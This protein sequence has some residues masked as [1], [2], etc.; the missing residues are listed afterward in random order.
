MSIVRVQRKVRDFFVA[1]NEIMN[2]PELSF[3]AKGLWAYAMSRP[4]DWQFSIEHLVT[5]SKE[6]RTAIYSAIKELIESGYCIKDQKKT[7]E[8]KW[9]SMDYVIFETLK[10]SE[11]FKKS[12]PHSGFPQ[13]DFPL[14]ENQPLLSTED[15]SPIS[16]NEQ[17]NEKYK[18]GRD[19]PSPSA[20]AEFLCTFFL[21]EIKKRIPDFKE[22]N[23][24]NWN[25]EMDRLLRMDKRNPDEVVQVIMWASGHNWWKSACLSPAK[26]RKAYEEMR[27][28]MFA[29]SERGQININRQKILA[30]KQQY[31]QELKDMFFDEKCVYNRSKGESLGLMMDPEEFEKAF[32]KMFG[33][34]H[35]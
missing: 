6:S 26:L 5:V 27:A 17:S 20:D 9:G 23:I 29:H 11:D 19:K 32:L 15:I 7:S 12:L 35:V 21:N 34:Y 28:Q 22:P 30:L 10:D 2:N 1:K 3:K 33:G 16:L 25:V 24:P 8:G 31:P 14:P 13:A 18:V 4:D